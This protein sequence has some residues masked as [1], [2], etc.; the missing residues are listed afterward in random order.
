MHG[1]AQPQ[2]Q[3][4]F[5]AAISRFRLPA[6][7]RGLMF[8]LAM[9]VLAALPVLVAWAPQ[10]T[11]YPSHLAGYKVALDHGQDPYLTRY[12]RFNWEWTGN[13]GVE[14]LMVPLT[15]IFG[16]EQA[17]RII[18]ALIPFLSVLSVHALCRSLGRK[19]GVGPILSLA[20]IWSPSLL[21]GFVNW[22]LSVALA[23]FVF[24]AWV[25]LEGKPWRW[26]V[27]VPASFVVWL[28]H[29]SGWGVMGV[30]IF[31]YEWAHRKSWRDWRPFLKPWPLIFPLLPML[32]GM[33]SNSKVSS[34]ASSTSRCA[35]STTRSISPACGS[36][37]ACWAGHW[38]CA[39]STGASVGR[40]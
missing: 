16:L 39:R 22:S 4:L 7:D 15:P 3:D 2:T 25:K 18:V 17:G 20:M 13:L 28:S 1:T 35:A 40:R 37:W 31:G 12:F 36:C 21:M 30:L 19:M 5:K 14:L 8:A 32:M 10:M 11:D 33:G 9:A 6:M 27:M 26:A 29:V 38:R 23:L 24:A 34:G